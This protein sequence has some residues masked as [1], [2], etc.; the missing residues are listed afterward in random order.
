MTTLALYFLLNDPYWKNDYKHYFLQ[1]S[2][3]LINEKFIYQQALYLPLL[4]LLHN[5]QTEKSM[6]S[7]TSTTFCHYE[8]MEDLY[9][10]DSAHPYNQW[11]SHSKTAN[12]P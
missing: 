3:P 11:S 5:V 7:M 8:N 12:G 4:T 10:H 1:V 2:H 6:K 9:T